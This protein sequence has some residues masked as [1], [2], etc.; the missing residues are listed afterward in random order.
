VSSQAQRADNV[1]KIVGFALGFSA[2]VAMPLGG[3]ADEPKLPAAV[4]LAISALCF[5]ALFSPRFR[6]NPYALV[7]ALNIVPL[8]LLLAARV[9]FSLDD[10]QRAVMYGIGELA[11]FLISLGVALWFAR[12]KRELDRHVF[13]LAA[14][15]AFFVLVVTLVVYGVALESFDAPTVNLRWFGSL[16][17]G[18]FALG[19]LV[20]EQRY[21]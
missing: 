4:G 14:A 10:E 12:F 21:E 7:I 6:R 17:L 19:L 8:G 1:A 11:S 20:F 9:I 13:T 5:V 2:A 15:T 16:G 3:A 18:A